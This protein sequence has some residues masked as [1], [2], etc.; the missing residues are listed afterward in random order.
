MLQDSISL[1]LRTV[2]SSYVLTGR[3]CTSLF[4]IEFPALT[5]CMTLLSVM[6][7]CTGRDKSESAGADWK[8]MML[9]MAG[10]AQEHKSRSWQVQEGTL[11]L[12]AHSTSAMNKYLII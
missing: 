6:P 2:A 1:L 3:Y 10:A 8:P 7:I 12:S 5:V 11:I 4:T 9:T